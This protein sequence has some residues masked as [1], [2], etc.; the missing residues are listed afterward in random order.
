[1]SII[2]RLNG[3]YGTSFLLLVLLGY[4]TQGLRCFPWTAMSYWY[5]D[6][7]KVDPGQMQFLMS[8]ATLPMVAKPVYGIISDSVYIKGAHRVP[9][10]IIAGALQL[11][12]WTAIVVHS[13]ASSSA[14]MLTAFLT[15]TNLGGA[16]S[17]VV[18]DAMIAEAGKNKVG[19]QQGELQSFAWL[20]LASGGVVGN[21]TAGYAM[22]VVPP[23]VM[24]AIFIILIA[25]QLLLALTV[26]EHSFALGPIKKDTDDNP[27]QKSH[28][29]QKDAG[30]AMREQ[31]TKLK[32]SLQKPEIFKP[33]LWFLSS[34]AVI[35]GLGSALF[36]YQTQYLRLGASVIGLARV[37][38]QVGLLFGSMLYNKC[39]KDVPI[40]RMFAT[41]QI[42][43][44][45]CML[46]DI[47]LVNRINLEFGIPDKWFVLGASAFVEA[48]GQFKILPFM[49]LLAKLCPPGSEASLFAFFMSAQ[50]LASLTNGYLGV[51]LASSLRISGNDFSGLPLG[52]FIQAFFALI[53]VLWIGLIPSEPKTVAVSQ[54]DEIETKK[55]L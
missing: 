43:L 20:A 41:V 31:I 51:V 25:T 47:L 26:S 8:T 23:Q 19:A 12:A 27:E 54:S 35:P 53:P 33:L 49:V 3:T 13:G 9:Y 37:I 1:M 46:T 40:R 15:I 4:F 39:L 28:E 18:N 50:C 24:L 45:L 32:E 29:R 30:A 14:A 6:T 48:I 55:E 5:K 17:E 16:I 10:L 11:F 21:L 7:L 34:Y 44:S 36:Y 22:K 2:T 52:I 42:L 38:G